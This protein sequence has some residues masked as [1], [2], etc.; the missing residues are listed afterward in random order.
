MVHEY[1]K[2]W[3]SKPFARLKEYLP[4]NVCQ[5]RSPKFVSACNQESKLMCLRKWHRTSRCR[6]DD[7]CKEMFKHFECKQKKT[8]ANKVVAN[9]DSFSWA[10]IDLRLFSEF[11]AINFNRWLYTRAYITGCLSFGSDL[12]WFCDVLIRRRLLFLKKRINIFLHEAATFILENGS[13]HFMSSHRNVIFLWDSS[14]GSKYWSISLLNTFSNNRNWYK[15]SQRE[16]ISKLY[17]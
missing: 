4:L 1:Q 17:R 2:Q 7:G 16:I 11:D 15:Y 6:V 13:I 3:R 9:E 8:D 14:A 5:R 10:I 12:A